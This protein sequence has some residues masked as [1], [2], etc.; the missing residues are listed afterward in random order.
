VIGLFEFGRE[1]QAV[2][3]P[4]R[5][6][7]KEKR[8]LFRAVAFFLSDRTLGMTSL[9]I[10]LNMAQLAENFKLAGGSEKARVFQQPPFGFD[11]GGLTH[12][13]GGPKCR[14]ITLQLGGSEKMAQRCNGSFVLLGLGSTRAAQRFRSAEALRSVF[15]L[16]PH[17]ANSRRVRQ[18]A[19]NRD[20]WN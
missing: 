20:V 1:D 4:E 10:T 12:N 7:D 11:N 13:V 16:V 3:T 18:G 5:A 9:L 17:F 8:A 6:A 14:P 15:R 19:L 2:M